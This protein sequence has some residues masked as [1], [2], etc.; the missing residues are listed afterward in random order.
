MDIPKHIHDTN[1]SWQWGLKDGSI[2]SA[3]RDYDLSHDV[4]WGSAT[5]SICGQIY[6]AEDKLGQ[7][8]ESDLQ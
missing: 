1:G 8:I 4:V 6:M 3:E 7:W 5:C 2:V